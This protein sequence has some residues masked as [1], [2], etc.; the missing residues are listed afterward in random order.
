[1]GESSEDVLYY[2]HVVMYISVTVTQDRG[3]RT[4]SMSS[5]APNQPKIWLT[6][7]VVCQCMGKA[8]LD[9]TCMTGS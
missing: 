2:T 6:W 3:L 4:E 9:R 5:R 7:G 8:M 1:M